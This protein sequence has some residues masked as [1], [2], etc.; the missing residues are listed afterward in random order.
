MFIFKF[1][2]LS[3]LFPHFVIKNF[4][5]HYPELYVLVTLQMLIILQAKV[6]SLAG[7]DFRSSVLDS[8]KGWIQVSLFIIVF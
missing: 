7:D 3:D 1:E 4:S 8:I 5:D 2:S 6:H